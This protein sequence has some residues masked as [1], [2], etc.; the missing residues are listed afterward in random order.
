[1][2]T[3]LAGLALLAALALV[4]SPAL[5]DQSK[6]Y[7]ISIHQPSKVGSHDLNAGDYK[8]YVDGSKVR[9]VELKSGD[10]IELEAKIQTVD[11]KHRVTAVHSKT[12]DGVP[13]IV[14]IRIGGS[15][16]SVEFE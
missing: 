9:F 5:A 15:K 10:E 2:K 7:K 12:V 14:A 13:V 8:L 4:V 6:S 11:E 3:F 16:T 1:M